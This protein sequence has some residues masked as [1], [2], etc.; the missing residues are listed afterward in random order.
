MTTRTEEDFL[1]KIEIPRAAYYGVHTVRAVH[2]F[3]V[4]GFKVPDELIRAL[5]EVKQ[6]C[7]LANMRVGLLSEEI[8]TRH[9][10]RGGRSG[11][12]QA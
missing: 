11:F 3:P 2:N 4:S 8:G 6:A 7:A 9:C 10:N 1:G 12:R 5:A